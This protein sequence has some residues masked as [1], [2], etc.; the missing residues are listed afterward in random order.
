ML[1]AF[2]CQTSGMKIQI[3]PSNKKEKEKWGS[4]QLFSQFKVIEN[5]EKRSGKRDTGN[6]TYQRLKF[7]FAVFWYETSV[8]V[9]AC[10]FYK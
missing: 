2:N 8:G 1:V 5:D 4:F 3:N 7:S 9:L 6:R 10:V